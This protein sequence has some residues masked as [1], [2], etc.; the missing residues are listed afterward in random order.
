MDRKQG[1]RIITVACVIIFLGL[2]VVLTLRENRRTETKNYGEEPG[3]RKQVMVEA[4]RQEVPHQLGGLERREVVKGP[5]AVI[6]IVS[7]HGKAF[8]LTGGT[9]ARYGRNGTDATLWIGDTPNPKAAADLVDQITEGI[10][11]GRLPF[12]GLEEIDTDGRTVYALSGIGQRHVYFAAGNRTVW[13]A[14]DSTVFRRALDDLLAA[15]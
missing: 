8:D 6:E 15:W 12:R 4:A 11:T 5:E 1:W 13:A 2:L 10:R 14:A 9:V 3:A 7:L